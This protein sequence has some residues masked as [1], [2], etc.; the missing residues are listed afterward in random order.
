VPF[1]SSL[2]N[3]FSCLVHVL[4]FWEKPVSQFL[5]LPPGQFLGLVLPFE[6]FAFRSYE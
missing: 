5:L 2:S 1:V 6:T 4:L 3:C